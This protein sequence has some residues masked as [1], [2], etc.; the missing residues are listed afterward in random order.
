MMRVVA[1]WIGMALLFSAAAATAQEP[2]TAA[3]AGVGRIIGRVTDAATKRPIEGAS[4]RLS[5][6]DLVVGVTDRRG[7]FTLSDVPAAVHQI[8]IEH[9]GYGRGTHL[10]NVPAGETVVFDAQLE[11]GA[12]RLD[13]LVI[14]ADV[15]TTQL[16]RVGFHRRARLGFGHF[17]SGDEVTRGRV[18]EAIYSVPRLE[19]VQMGRGGS[20]RVVFRGARFTCTPGIYVDGIRQNWADGDIEQVV[21]GREIEAMEVHRGMTTPAEFTVGY[22]PCGA[23]VVWTRWLAR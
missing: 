12:I 4:L 21:I 2:R 20:R 19:F 22:P 18:R 9:I 10:V 11:A 23:I 15:R 17:F 13:S 1:G 7:A 8:E 3:D 5:D 16:E 14:T 6:S